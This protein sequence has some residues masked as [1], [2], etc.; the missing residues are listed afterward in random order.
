MNL[1]LYRIENRQH[2]VIRIGLTY[3]LEFKHKIK[4]IHY[5]YKHNILCFYF[6]LVN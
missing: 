1:I 4:M 2:E 3:N 5:S 6:D